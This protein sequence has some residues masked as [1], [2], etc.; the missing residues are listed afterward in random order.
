MAYR[1]NLE[2]SIVVIKDEKSDSSCGSFPGKTTSCCIHVYIYF[3]HSF[4]LI[5]LSVS[6]K[7]RI[8][9]LEALNG[10]F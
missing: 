2:N 4:R 9:V 8:S 1:C 6:F 5:D 7:L 10:K 3:L